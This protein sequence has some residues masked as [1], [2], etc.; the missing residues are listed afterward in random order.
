M[1]KAHLTINRHTPIIPESMW[2]G[3]S[4]PTARVFTKIK[5]R[6]IL[7]NCGIHEITRWRKVP[8][9]VY[10][11]QP[12]PPALEI[13]DKMLVDAERAVIQKYGI[14]DHTIKEYLE[15]RK[16]GPEAVKK[17]RICSTAELV[18]SLDPD[19]VTNL[20]LR[21]PDKLKQFVTT[22]EIKGVSFPYY[23]DNNHKHFF[24]G[25]ATRIINEP[26][27]K[28]AFTV[29]N[30]LCFGLD[31]TKDEVYVVEGVF[32][33]IAMIMQGYNALG[34]GDSQPNFFK[35]FYTSKFPKINLLF[36][37]D[38]AGWLGALKAHVVLTDMF[39]VPEERI[40][41]LA[42]QNGKDPGAAIQAT[43]KVV[44]GKTTFSEALAIAGDLGS[45]LNADDFRIEVNDE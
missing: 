6:H 39:D 20:S 29:P 10:S 38:Y 27:V 11:L 28:Y 42:L 9:N 25:F 7:P 8:G 23:F 34:M 35:M 16:I 15:D 43:G 26:L 45:R 31:R 22:T 18:A 21:V 12:T 40:S 13:T 24:C 2:C 5:N 14:F 32:D 4:P 33:A 30:R 1:D 44:F 19:T 36:D 17:F 41:I 37:N 3:I